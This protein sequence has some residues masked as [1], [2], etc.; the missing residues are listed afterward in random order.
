[1]L[2]ISDNGPRRTC[3]ELLACKAP[4]RSR[5]SSDRSH[6]TILSDHRPAAALVAPG[7]NGI[8]RRSRART[9]TSDRG[10]AAR[11]YTGTEHS[12]N[13]ASL[14]RA[15]TRKRRIRWHDDLHSVPRGDP[16]VLLCRTF[17]VRTSCR[18]LAGSRCVSETTCC[19][20]RRRHRWTVVDA[21]LM[22]GRICVSRRREYICVAGDSH[23]EREW[24]RRASANASFEVSF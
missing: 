8:F 9:H 19:R 4:G 7:A 11:C 21:C 6:R 3:G 22:H 10:D 24:R 17:A 20:C 1:M 2:V 14:S 23:H 13:A 5:Q 15:R 18:V 16:G 12:L